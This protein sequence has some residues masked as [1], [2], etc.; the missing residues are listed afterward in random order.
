MS[1]PP[2]SVSITQLTV[3]AVWAV[4]IGP[5]LNEFVGQLGQSEKEWLVRELGMGETASASSSQSMSASPAPG[6]REW[7]EHYIDPERHI[8]HIAGRKVQCI[9]RAKPLFKK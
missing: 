6:S 2:C 7:E 1:L 4:G 8:Y 5:L 3:G 9:T